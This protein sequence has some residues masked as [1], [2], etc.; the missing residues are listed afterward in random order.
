MLFRA[1]SFLSFFGEDPVCLE[2]MDVHRIA[3]DLESNSMRRNLRVFCGG[4][5][6]RKTR[7]HDKEQDRRIYPAG[8]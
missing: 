1:S 8:R 5:K 3:V 7:R 6:L 4:R 2:L